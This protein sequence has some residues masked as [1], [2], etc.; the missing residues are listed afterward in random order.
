M[1]T[2][3]TT[4]APLPWM[5]PYLQDYMSRAQGVANTPY[6]ASPQTYTGPNNLLTQG[7]QAVVNRAMQGSPVMSAANQ[8]LQNTINGGFMSRQA[9][10]NTNAGQM[11][12]YANTAN[13]Q[14]QVFNSQAYTMNPNAGVGNN[15]ANV[16][17]ANAGQFNSYAGT[18]NQAANVGNQYLGA[19]NP[20]AQMSNP[21]LS[22]SIADAQGDLV[23]SYNLTQK[24]AWDKAMQSSGSFG[25]SGV[26]EMQ[27][28]SQNDLMK[29]LGR[30]GTDM[31]M[32]A[33][34]Q[35]ANLNENQ[36][37][38]MFSSGE[39]QAGRQFN[40]GE[41]MAS[42][43][44]GAGQ[45][46]A[47]NLY[48]SGEAM[49]GRQFNAGAATQA[50]L[51]NAGQ[52]QSQNLYGA[53]QQQANNLFSAGNQQAQN[54][55]NAGNQ[56]AQNMFNAGESQ[57]G[58]QDAITGQERGFQQSAMGM[59]PQFANQ[60]YVDANNLLNAGQQRQAF[61]QG[62]ADQNYRWWQEAQNYPRQQLAAYGQALGQG[63]GGTQTQNAPDPSTASQ[64]LGGG[65]TGA[66]IYRMLFGG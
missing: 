35:A 32:N 18:A 34:N 38:R 41:N 3:T 5:E 26:M 14:A 12:P 16:G 56:Y 57:A 13:D 64:L 44:Y 20:F 29:N 46:Q 62:Q 61:D 47:Q 65:L 30:I 28:N 49:A 36:V 43:L 23:K 59:A 10:G 6:Q 7:W 37:G 51:F 50:N 39:A 63:Q 22:Q 25:N 54:R 1:P 60:D 58:R 4:N 9:A 21:Y 48:N 27:Q 45:Q 24:P 53:G 8:Q 52:Q 31:R 17:N 40:A 15:A 33:Y 55:F 19:S 11:N 2:Y 42:R 66:A